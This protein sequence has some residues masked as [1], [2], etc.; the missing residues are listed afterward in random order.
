MRLPRFKFSIRTLLITVTV[1][2]AILG[3]SIRFGPHVV[4][5]LFTS[6]RAVLRVVP[7]ADPPPIPSKRLVATAPD[8]LVLPANDRLVRCEIGPLSFEMPEA[9]TRPLVERVLDDGH[10][11]FHDGTRRILLQLPQ[12]D[13]QFF[14]GQL[15][16]FPDKAKLTYPRLHHE[17]LAAQSSDFSWGMSHR[18]L[19]WHQW[20]LS[21]RVQI[22]IPI[23]SVEYLW[24]PDLE[25]N[26]LHLPPGPEFQWATV[27]LKWQGIINFRGI[28]PEDLGWIRHLCT[29]L[30]INGDPGEFKGRSGDE[31][32]AM[33][34]ITELDQQR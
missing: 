33:I 27:D 23:E 22:F 19:R 17:I 13:D 6:P 11:Q 5:K 9:M 28:S 16:S 14:Q 18:E 30:V 21:K 26:L 31:I 12:P 1:F 24:R 4:W 32:E 25:G 3:L 8:D 15:T 29:T 7:H 10:L 20:L 2:G 34:R